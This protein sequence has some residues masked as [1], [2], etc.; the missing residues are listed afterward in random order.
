[1]SEKI[2]H[3][4]SGRSGVLEI[5]F[6]SSQKN[7]KNIRVVC[8][9]EIIHYKSMN[10]VFAAWE[11]AQWNEAA[12]HGEGDMKG[13][14]CGV[15]GCD[16]PATCKGFCKN[17]WVK[18]LRY[19]TVAE[20]K[21]VKRLQNGLYKGHRREYNSWSNMKQRCLN[22]RRAGFQ[23]Y[24]GRGVRVCERWLD[25]VY[26]FSNF[27]HDMGP[28]P[29]HT[30]LDR[31]DVDGDYFPENCLWSDNSSQAFNKRP[32][33][34]STKVTGVTRFF[35]NGEAYFCAYI[36]KN[37]EYRQKRFRSFDDAVLW[38]AKQEEELYG[39]SNMQVDKIIALI[40][41]WGRQHKINNPDK[42]LLHCYEEVAEIGR[43][44]IRGDYDKEELTKELGDV[45]VTTIILADI[46]G[47]DAFDCME[48]AF[49]K[50]QKRT[51]KTVNGNFIKSE[52]LNEENR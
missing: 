5:D 32:R 52:D 26:G 2:I 44:V 21:C 39:T 29:P 15:L 30:S 16:R 6:I 14:R 47:Y 4:R 20:D 7:A 36:S 10:D 25:P 43:L 1:M 17:H 35:L 38:R 28:R 37:Y 22:S 42:Q 24:G 41:D 23:D 33:M 40:K 31:K 34:H 45:F 49:L 18:I 46:F 51:G 50:I 9:E 19:G 27:L 11:L 3:R 8:D 13:L 12:W 48:K